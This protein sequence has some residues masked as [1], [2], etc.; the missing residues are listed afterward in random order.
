MFVPEGR[1]RHVS[2]GRRTVRLVGDI[3]LGCHA[4]EALE[5]VVAPGLLAENV[6]AKTAEIEQG[7]FSGAIALAMFGR[8]GE[9]LMK[10]RLDFRADGRHLRRA[11]ARAYH[12]ILR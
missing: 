3:E 7:P 2:L 4:P 1:I 10:L 12:T 5:I 8:A 9:I 11:V 6:H